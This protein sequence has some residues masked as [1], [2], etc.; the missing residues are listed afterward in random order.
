MQDVCRG[1]GVGEVYG[2]AGRTNRDPQDG[3]FYLRS[4]KGKTKRNSP[5]PP[6]LSPKPSRLEGQLD[7]FTVLRRYCNPIAES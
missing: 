5:E 6:R 3:K 7:D 4:K 1:Y 2:P